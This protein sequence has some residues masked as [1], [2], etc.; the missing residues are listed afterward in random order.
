MKPKELYERILNLG[1]KIGGDLTTGKQT[2][3]GHFI[4]NKAERFIE[5][6]T[7]IKEDQERDLDSEWSDVYCDISN[8]GLVKGYLVGQMLDFTD[9]EILK[10][11]EVIKKE[12]TKQGFFSFTPRMR[13]SREKKAA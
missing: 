13:Q 6:Y 12:F 10:N 7:K 3:V 11:L 1:A 8:L 2:T 9:P 5:K 4:E